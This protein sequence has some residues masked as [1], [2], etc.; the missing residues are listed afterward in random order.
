M[1]QEGIDMTTDNLG[2]AG[3]RLIAI[4]DVAKTLCMSVKTMERRFAEGLLPLPERIGLNK[5]RVYRASM[6]PVL[7]EHVT[8]SSS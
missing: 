1:K 3:D 5:K 8:R 6:I 7:I 2:G 4:K